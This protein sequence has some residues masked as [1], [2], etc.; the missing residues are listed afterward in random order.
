[1]SVEDQVPYER[2]HDCLSYLAEEILELQSK[3]SAKEMTKN[4][5]IRKLKQEGNNYIRSRN[6]PPPPP[7]RERHFQMLIFRVNFTD[8]LYWLKK[9]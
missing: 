1:M 6:A 4:L 5:M 2:N 7:Q 3:D 8:I 9:I